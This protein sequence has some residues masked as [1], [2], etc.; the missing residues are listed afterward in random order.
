MRVLV[1]AG[2]VHSGQRTGQPQAGSHQT[3]HFGL[4]D[5]IGDLDKEA[6]D[7]VKKPTGLRST[8]P[9]MIPPSRAI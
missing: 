5:A 8:T 6:T 4:G 1:G 3:R 7:P 9:V 2:A